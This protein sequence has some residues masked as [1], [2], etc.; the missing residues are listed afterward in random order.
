MCFTRMKANSMVSSYTNITS[1]TLGLYGCWW[2]NNPIQHNTLGNSK[3]DV[4]LF[5]GRHC[6]TNFDEEKDAINA[7]YNWWGTINRRRI[8]SRIFDMHSWNNRLLVNVSPIATSGDF[9]NFTRPVSE[10]NSSVN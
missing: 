3:M 8:K 7:K 9:S 2:E 6:S 1:S 5:L 4:E 10:F